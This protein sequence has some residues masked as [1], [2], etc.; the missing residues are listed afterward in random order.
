MYKCAISN[1]AVLLYNK[2]Y[3]VTK[4]C[5]HFSIVKNECAI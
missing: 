3:V 2:V 5:V 4:Y 1:L